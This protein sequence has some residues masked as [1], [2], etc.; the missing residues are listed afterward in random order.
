MNL[1]KRLTHYFSIGYITRNNKSYIHNALLCHGYSSFSLTILN[2][3]DVSNLSLDE[4]KTLILQSEQHY[5]D[6]LRPKYNI[7]KIAGS[8][9]G[10]EH[11]LKTRRLMSIA[12]KGK[13]FSNEHK[14]KLSIVKLSENNPL[15][16]K[17]HDKNHLEKINYVR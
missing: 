3:I 5:I 13:S 8:L 9:L 7:L 2:Y 15:Y 14:I 12:K 11:S 16:G 1:S 17:S 10:R 4:A 6:T